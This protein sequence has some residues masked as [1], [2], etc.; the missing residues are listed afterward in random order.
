MGLFPLVLGTLPSIA[1]PS[2]EDLGRF[3]RRP[4]SGRP[5]TVA[6]AVGIN[7]NQFARDRL[8][9]T[10]DA[11][12]SST[13]LASPQAV[14]Q[15]KAKVED[16]GN[17]G[18]RL[19]AMTAYYVSIVSAILAL[20]ASKER[21]IADID[22]SVTFVVCGAG[23]L[24][25]LLWFFSLRFFRALFQAKLTVLANMEKTLP[26]QT[27]EPEFA[28][29]RQSG[30]RNWLWFERLVPIVFGSFFVVIAAIRPFL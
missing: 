22:T 20:L 14:E 28:L 5:K 8:F 12:P 15:Y 1:H 17:L 10:L 30:S 23:L 6:T 11:P 2:V 3:L 27:F 13:T 25:S 9:V 7:T 19:S 18:N 26:Y 29:M 16:L 4:C 24:V 21:S